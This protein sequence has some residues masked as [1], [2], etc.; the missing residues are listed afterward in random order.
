M[1]TQPLSFWSFLLLIASVPFLGVASVPMLGTLVSLTDLLSLVTLLL[2]ALDVAQRRVHLRGS[3]LFLVLGAY[4]LAIVVSGLLSQSHRRSLIKAPAELYLVTLAAIT[5]VLVDGPARMRL[6]VRTWLG[7]TG[8]VV[9]ATMIGILL[10]FLGFK[11]RHVNL[12]LWGFGSLPPGNYPRVKGLFANGN[13]FCNYLIVSAMLTLAAQQLRLISLR[14][15]SLLLAGIGVSM[16]FTISPGLGGAALCAGLWIRTRTR[17]TR[18]Q[19]WG[20]LALVAGIVAA[21]GFLAVTSV[22]LG[23]HSVQPSSRVLAWMQAW[24]HFVAHPFF[25]QGVGTDPVSVFWKNPAGLT[26]HL[27]EAHSL[28]LSIAAQEGGV[29]LLA[30]VGIVA[31]V[32]RGWRRAQPAGEDRVILDA[33]GVAFVGAVL[34][35]GLSGAFEDTRHVWLLIG[36]LATSARAGSTVATAA[37][38]TPA[39]RSGVRAAV[40]ATSPSA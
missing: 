16:V 35:H 20:A 33:L 10:F 24:R 4:A 13:M 12:V 21:V 32:L 17:Q 31:F 6:V 1:G 11:D 30:F 22:S 9:A 38:P 36:L 27:T 26:E 34:Y 14:A 7:A 29:G 18:W 23:G 8:V 39:E 19:I 28:W 5:F 25:G 40:G 37:E 3:G 15:A 2:L